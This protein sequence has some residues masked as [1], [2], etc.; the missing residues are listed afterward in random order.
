LANLFD[1][2]EAPAG[3]PEEV[4]VGDYIQWTRNDLATDYPPAD[5]TATYVA[6]ITGGGASEIQLTGTTYQGGYL[7]SV[8]STTSAGFTAGYYHWQLEIVRN[9]DGNRVVVDTGAFTAKPDLDVNNV[10]PRSHAEIMLDKIES[11]LQGRADSDVANYTIGNRSLTKLPIKDLLFWRDKYKSEVI[12]EK[13]KLRAMQG[14]STG[15]NVLI[16][17]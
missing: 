4:V 8:T 2:T 16:R 15:Q 1:P 12:K 10:D 13:Q 11:L 5:Y 17:F 7:F 6:R 9:S 3:E 14:K